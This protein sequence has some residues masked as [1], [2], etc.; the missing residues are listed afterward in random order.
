MIEETLTHDERLRLECVAQSV[1]MHSSVM[2]P[3]SAEQIVH[4]AK[5]F[6]KY[7]IGETSH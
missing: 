1:S 5:S 6:E 3:K 2:G 7:I 4:A